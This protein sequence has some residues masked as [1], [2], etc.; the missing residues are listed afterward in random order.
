M[1]ILL[2]VPTDGDVGL[3]SFYQTSFQQLGHHVCMLG[4]FQSNY[5][6]SLGDRVK[7][8]LTH[9]FEFVENVVLEKVFNRL[10]MKAKAYEPDVIVVFRCEFLS[11]ETVRQ[12]SSLAKSKIVNIYPDSPNVIPGANKI[13]RTNALHCYESVFT[14]SRSLIPV[15]HQ[16]GA[17][18]VH[19]LPFGYC[20]N[21]HQ[22]F[23]ITGGVQESIAYLGTWGPIQEYWLKPLITIGLNI[24]GINWE[25]LP[26]GDKLRECWQKEEGIGDEMKVVIGRAKVIFNLVRAEHGCAHSMKTFEIP[27]CGGFMLTNRTEEQCSFFQENEEAVYFDSV[28]EMVEKARYYLE[29]ERDRER[30]RQAGVKAVARHTYRSRA[31]GLLH[32]FDTGEYSTFV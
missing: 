2:I 4:C 23:Q 26:L 10:V 15:F 32:Y 17:K 11:S 13:L 14:F 25:H 24:Y 27:A 3:G 18:Q 30:I 6:P 16:L 29:H 7:S 20:P 9:T 31:E 19:W 12:L 1:R 28:E 22:P 8:K 21:A 5:Y